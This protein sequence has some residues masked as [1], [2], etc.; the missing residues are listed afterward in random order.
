MMATRCFISRKNEL[1]HLKAFHKKKITKLI[2]FKD[3]RRVV[4]SLLINSFGSS[5]SKNEQVLLLRFKNINH[6]HAD[7]MI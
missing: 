1:D 3:R 6:T 2:V 4:K 7:Q 5:C